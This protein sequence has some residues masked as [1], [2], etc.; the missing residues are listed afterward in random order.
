MADHN[1]PGVDYSFSRPSPS[2]LARSGYRFALRYLSHDPKKDLSAQELKG[3]WGA[4]LLVGL[5]WE[6]TGGRALEGEAAGKADATEA[7][8]Q[9]DALALEG[10]PIFFAVD[11]DIT[12]AQKPKVGRYFKGAESVLGKDRTRCYGGFYAIKYLVEKKIGASDGHWQTAAWSGGQWHPK[13]GIRQTRNGVSTAG[14]EVDL[15]FANTA[16]LAALRGPKAKPSR[17][18]E[19][20]RKLRKWE[21]ELH[22]IRE[23]ADLRRKYGSKH[24]WTLA[25]RVR[26]RNLKRLIARQERRLRRK[27]APVAAVTEL[28]QPSNN[29]GG[30]MHPKITL[31]QIIGAVGAAVAPIC[32]L[33]GVHLSPDQ[34]NAV[35]NLRDIGL[36]LFGADAIVRVARNYALSKGQ[37]PPQK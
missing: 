19:D 33:A 18:Q 20:E 11:F 21:R 36:G 1:T 25:M 28:R 9:A 32:L 27:S 23:E 7:K 4:G 26:A 15:N 16:G 3:L 2:Q 24:P 12:P 10:I 6:S 35:A 17:R 37:V 31:P 34:L 30:S 29:P 5:V 13:A 14:G 8:A 22:G